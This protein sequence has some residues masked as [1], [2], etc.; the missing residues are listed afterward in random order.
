MSHHFIHIVQNMFQH[1]LTRAYKEWVCVPF[2]RA[3]RRFTSKKIERQS[4]WRHRNLVSVTSEERQNESSVHSY[5][6]IWG[7][8]FKHFQGFFQMSALK[9]L[10]VDP[11]FIVS[12]RILQKCLQT[13]EFWA[14]QKWDL[15]VSFYKVSQGSGWRGIFRGII[16]MMSV[17]PI[18]ASTQESSVFGGLTSFFKE[19]DPFVT[20]PAHLCQP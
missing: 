20:L 13:A 19:G 17:E 6:V 3:T 1:V 9:G 12:K 4:L 5:L 16:Y 11:K 18:N 15:P 2:N 10:W 8:K 14:I 7:L